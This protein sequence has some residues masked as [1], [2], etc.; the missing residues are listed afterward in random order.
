[1]NLKNPKMSIQTT[2][3]KTVSIKLTHKEAVWLSTK[4][5]RIEREHK[6]AGTPAALAD[7]FMA[8]SLQ[9]RISSE[10]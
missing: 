8:A 2:P 4:L 3:K 7:A 1:L 6:L 10:S 5:E 9:D